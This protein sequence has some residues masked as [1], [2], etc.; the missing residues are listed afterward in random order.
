MQV[1]V[2]GNCQVL[3]VATAVRFML[4][5]AAVRVVPV[6]SMDEAGWERLAHELLREDVVLALQRRTG[7][8]VLGPAEY[9]ATPSQAIVVMPPFT[10]PGF[11]PDM[12]YVKRVGGGY[13]G[14]SSDYSSVL[15]VY[16]FLAGL[17]PA[18]TRNLYRAEIYE[19]LGWNFSAAVTALISR[20]AEFG[21]DV[22]GL[23]PAWLS[24]GPFMTTINHPRLRPVADVTRLA[25]EKV[26]LTLRPGNVA[27]YVVDPIFTE[28]WPVPP[29]FAISGRPGGPLYKLRGLAS[30]ADGGTPVFLDLDSYIDRVFG[31]LSDAKSDEIVF[32]AFQTMSK[33]LARP[34][35]A[36]SSAP[37]GPSRPALG[38]GS[39]NPY[40]GLPDFHWWDKAV[41][42]VP[43]REIQPMVQASFRL[44][45]TD[46][47][48]A[49]GSCFAQH[50][51]RKLVSTGFSYLVT[52]SAP[53]GMSPE[54]VVSRSYGVYTARYGNIYTPRQMVQLFR[55]AFG[56]LRPWDTVWASRR[57]GFI[58]PFRPEIEPGGFGS[59]E[60]VLKD[61]EAHLLAVREM[62]MG[63]NTLIFTLGLTETW[64]S[65]V[66]GMVFPVAPGAV[67][68]GLDSGGYEFINFDYLEVRNDLLALVD[69]VR[70]VNPLARFVLTVS[71]VPLVATYE[72]R[73]VLVS[74][75]A[76]KSIL[77]AAADEVCRLR[78]GVM[79]FPSYEII[80][81][82]AARGAYYQD[83]LRTVT[84]AGVD[85]V[86]TAF[87]E[88]CT[89]GAS[90][91]ALTWSGLEEIEAVVC[92]EEVV[93]R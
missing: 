63:L 78:P 93:A 81:L 2:I 49:A 32:P 60:S 10:F 15:A 39:A 25:L 44:A 90:P 41:T 52:E 76:S 48:A 20:Y 18:E 79:Y 33:K 67:S 64:R 58:D 13:L 73:H 6:R 37:V 65:K 51:T 85:H 74:T 87:L 9:D 75:V 24:D 56:M 14:P 83:D 92:D 53:A 8:V 62:F 89:Y 45:P 42:G 55:R 84:A 66:D 28:I 21:L 54:E 38:A 7:R 11:H 12:S 30:G 22:Q 31:A 4:P 50:M 35:F 34:A 23:L 88:A 47:V 72:D 40:R 36:A 69:E 80:T 19:A 77:R 57:G 3:S 27:D 5:D 82:P 70:Q 29:G 61:R 68:D 16:G 17:T 1:V 71:P 26:G 86:M 43:L 46:A 91:E 59:P